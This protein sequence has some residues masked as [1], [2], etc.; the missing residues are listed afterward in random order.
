MPMT[1]E[2]PRYT[3]ELQALRASEGAEFTVELPLSP[4]PL[5]EGRGEG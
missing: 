3:D 4:L 1:R 2:T 5:G